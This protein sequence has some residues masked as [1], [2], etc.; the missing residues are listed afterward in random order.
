MKGF[1]L[2]EHG[3]VVIENGEIQMV[4]DVELTAQTI[5]SVLQTQKGE[6][7]LDWEEGINHNEILGKKRYATNGDAISEKY[8]K[9]IKEI[10]RKNAEDEQALSDLLAKRLDGET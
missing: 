5:K 10:E 4:H 7:F 1:M 2:D 6:W 8:T 3:D 9:E